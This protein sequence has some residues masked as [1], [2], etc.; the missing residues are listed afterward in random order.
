LGDVL[1]AAF[2]KA[3]AA[4][5]LLTGDDIS[6]LGKYYLTPYD[7]S[8]ERNP[9]PQARPNVLF[10]A[11]MAFGKYSRRTVLVGLGPTRPFSDVV[12]RLVVRISNDHESRQKLANRLRNA[13]CDVK[14]DYKSDW[15]KAGDFDAALRNPDLPGG[16]IL[17][18]LSVVK[19]EASFTPDAT[20]K[21]KVWIQ[22]R[23]ETDECL[24]LRDP[25]WK[26][27]LG[28]MKGA[29]RSQTIQLKLGPYWCPEKIGVDRLHLP[30]GDLCKLWI[31]PGE[32]HQMDALKQLCESE[33]PLG[34]LTITANSVHVPISV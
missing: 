12:G 2:E 20:Y 30:P 1:E 28:G 25:S 11:G 16:K 4:V 10:E 22:L 27:A 29:I 8:D 24:E 13:G 31:E 23:N 5:V 21:R 15:L 33:T 14:I 9:T 17:V 6:R 26:G 34:V 7:T 18:R 32:E 19:R 3:Q